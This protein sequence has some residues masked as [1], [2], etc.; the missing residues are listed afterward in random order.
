MDQHLQKSY[1]Q[2]YIEAYNA[3]NVDAML[4]NLHHGIEFKNISD[5]AVNVQLNG[6]EA[7]RLQAEQAQQFFQMREQRITNFTFDRDAVTVEVD[8]QAV[9][10]IDLPNGMKKG[11]QIHLQGKTIFRFQDEKITSI[12][13]IS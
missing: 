10:A 3:F 12:T 1:I 13:D 6:I 9:M 5:G 11:D 4:K 7:F 2:E 8:Y